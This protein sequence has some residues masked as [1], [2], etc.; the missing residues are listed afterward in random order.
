MRHVFHM[1]SSG[2]IMSRSRPLSITCVAQVRTERQ[3]NK[4]TVRA[5]RNV[6]H[7]CTRACMAATEAASVG[8]ALPSTPSF[9]GSKMRT[10]AGP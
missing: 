4:A 9:V 2:L 7:K 5:C 8:G 10:P 1:R 6:P 3:L